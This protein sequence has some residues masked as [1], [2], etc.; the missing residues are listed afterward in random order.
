M[1]K[2]IGMPKLKKHVNK[3]GMVLSQEI[4]V[5]PKIKQTSSIKPYISTYTTI[6]QKTNSYNMYGYIKV[7]KL[8]VVHVSSS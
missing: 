1:K 8:Y 4:N 3:V 7:V 5:G 6:N 2:Y